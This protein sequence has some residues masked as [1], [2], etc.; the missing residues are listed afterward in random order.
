MSVAIRDYIVNCKYSIAPR[1]KHFIE[2]KIE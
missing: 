1:L 2:G